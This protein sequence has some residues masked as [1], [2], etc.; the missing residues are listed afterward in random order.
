MIAVIHGI[1]ITATGLGCL[2]KNRHL[3]DRVGQIFTQLYIDDS[4]VD[5]LHVLMAED[6]IRH[7]L[8]RYIQCAVERFPFFGCQQ[9]IAVRCKG[10]CVNVANI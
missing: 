8:W 7:A 2:E 5:D 4:T 6:K 10:A 9:D 1:R 3:T